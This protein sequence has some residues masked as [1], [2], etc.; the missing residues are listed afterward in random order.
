MIMR[1]LFALTLLFAA[2]AQSFGAHAYFDFSDAIGGKTNSTI[3]IQPTSIYTDGTN[4]ITTE[5]LTYKGITNG[6]LTVSNHAAAG[7]NLIFLVKINTA[8]TNNQF[9]YYLPASNALFNA[10]NYRVLKPSEGAIGYT[11]GQVDALIASIPTS[12]N[13]SSINTNDVE[14]I[15]AATAADGSLT[16]LTVGGSTN[17]AGSISLN[18]ASGLTREFTLEAASAVTPYKW[19][20][21][22]A[23]G[24]GYVKATVSGTNVTLSYD[25]PTTSGET[26]TLIDIPDKD[27]VDDAIDAAVLGAGTVTPES[28]TNVVQANNKIT[29]TGGWLTNTGSTKLVGPVL[30]DDDLSVAGT[31][32][33]PFE[34]DVTGDATFH[35][36]A[37]VARLIS[38]NATNLSINTNGNGVIGGG[39]IAT[40]GTIN[41]PGSSRFEGP[42]VADDDMQVAGTLTAQFELITEGSATLRGETTVGT[43]G[44]ILATNFFINTNGNGIAGGVGLTNGTATVTSLTIGTSNR[45]SWPDAATP[46]QL[47][48]TSN[49]VLTAS[50]DYANGLLSVV[51][52]HFYFYGSQA[53]NVTSIQPTGALFFASPQPSASIGITNAIT[54]SNGVANQYFWSAITTN[55]YQS[56][57]G[58]AITVDFN[59]FETA[60]GSVAAYHIETYMYDETNLVELADSPDQAVPT[61]YSGTGQEFINSYV[62][63]NSSVPFRLVFRAKAVTVSGAPVVQVLSEGSFDTHAALALPSPGF[64]MSSDLVTATNDAYS[65]TRSVSNSSYTVSSNVSVALANTAMQT[66]TNYA[67][68]V[69]NASIIRTNDTTWFASP[70]SLLKFATNVTWNVNMPSSGSLVAIT[71]TLGGSTANLW[72]TNVVDGGWFTA[73][74]LADGTAR[75]ISI[76]NASALTLT[77]ISTNGFSG[78][79][80]IPTVSIT[81]SKAGLICGRATVYAGVTNVDLW[82]A[83]QP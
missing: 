60:A 71:N 70:S 45:T 19:I 18:D 61:A 32:T 37:N 58:G 4:I 10:W 80:T 5:T 44:S 52:S 7:T 29:P 6:R 33:A 67:N 50:Q 41:V 73:R 24:S 57:P 15:I 30:M 13:T 16:N 31:I 48:T 1:I 62:A 9:Y 79:G 25:T 23:A 75:T 40:N 74:I 20:T 2:V 11:R 21:P 83:I 27:Y 82:A 63:T 54:L 46:D 35:G 51:G 38:I 53:S 47:T 77:V 3:T 72:L 22:G 49:G 59:C 65:Y 64:A 28:V 12:T 42:I 34:L 55:H 76:T 56:L 68:G 81:A 66:S 17:R 26:F 43:L 78:V 8:R 69:T 36:A 14:A 39:I